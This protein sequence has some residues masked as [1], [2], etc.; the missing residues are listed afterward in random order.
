M[1]QPHVKRSMVIAG[2]PTSLSLEPVFWQ[3]L[4]TMAAARACSLS[5]LIEDIDAQARPASLASA[6]R[7]AALN[8][9]RQ[10]AAR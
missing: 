5:Q 3:A 2:H 7:V 4:E 6:L 9:Y 8:Y 10:Q 1:A